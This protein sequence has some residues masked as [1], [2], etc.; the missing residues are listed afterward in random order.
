MDQVASFVET[1]NGKGLLHL[2]P[3]RGIPSLQSQPGNCKLQHMA[4]ARALV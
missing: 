3:S 1:G 2:A 4:Q